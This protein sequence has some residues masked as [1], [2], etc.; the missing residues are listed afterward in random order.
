MKTKQA[1]PG[2]TANCR[3]GTLCASPATLPAARRCTGALPCPL[4]A[5]TT[6]W[7]RSRLDSVPCT[8]RGALWHRSE[9]GAGPALLRGLLDPT[10]NR[11]HAADFNG[12]IV[13]FAADC[14]GPIAVHEA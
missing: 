11:H 8:T 13:T 14:V 10:L 9:R 3:T 6:P 1:Y 12:Q 5:R 4:P 7:R 2:P